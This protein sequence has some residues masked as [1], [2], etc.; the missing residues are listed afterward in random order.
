MPLLGNCLP[1]LSSEYLMAMLFGKHTQGA[2][3]KK[4]KLQL[5]TKRRTFT[6]SAKENAELK[7]SK[8][9][10]KFNSFFQS[11]PSSLKAGTNFC[12]LCE[13]SYAA[14]ASCEHYRRAKETRVIHSRTFMHY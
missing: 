10:F 6:L 5:D 7:I 9:S 3:K 12:N 11:Q 2:I 1:S 4:V 13:L 8:A 14:A